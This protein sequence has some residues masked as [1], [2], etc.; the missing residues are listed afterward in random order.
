[1]VGTIPYDV[2]DKSTSNN[3]YINADAA[4]CPNNFDTS[5]GTYLAGCCDD[6]SYDVDIY[7]NE[8]AAAILGDSDCQALGGTEISVCDYMTN[9]AN[10][11]IF[12]NGYPEDFPG[13]VWEWLKERAVLVRMYLN[14]SG[15][16]WSVNDGWFGSTNHCSWAGVTCTTSNQVTNLALDNKQLVGSFPNDLI[17]LPYLESLNLS[18]NS[19]VGT[20]PYDVC[21]KSTSN[22]LYI[23]AD[24]ANCPNNFDTSTG[25]YLAGCCDDISYDVDIYLNEF[26]AAILGDSDCASFVGVENTVCSFMTNKENHDIF[27]NGYPGTSPV[28]IWE[29]LKERSIL[30]RMYLNTI[31]QSWNIQDNWLG[32]DNH[33]T[34]AGVTCST[35]GVVTELALQ[36]NML[37]GPFPNDLSDLGSLNTLDLSA[38]YMAGIIPSDLCYRSMSNSLYIHADVANCPNSIDVECCDLVYGLTA[39]PSLSPSASHSIFPTAS[40][41]HSFSIFPSFHMSWNVTGNYV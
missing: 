38:N 35:D 3:L 6:I 4:N 5:T 14:T 25:T 41:S 1:M 20:I 26:A 8:F 28:G 7:L 33:C 10:H 21:D 16:T 34:W 2:C 13:G 29:W 9:K 30:V 36:N 37:S 27:I 19:M 12:A 15:S 23:N 24:A 32:Y 31:G 22:N 40:V 17:Y 18:S 11:D 39:V